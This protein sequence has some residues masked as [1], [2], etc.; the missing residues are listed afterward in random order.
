MSNFTTDVYET[1]RE[2]TNFSKTI[3]SGLDKPE[4]KFIMD[5]MYGVHHSQNVLLSEIS[6][7]LNEPIK[8]SNTIERL[9]DH[10][11]F[12]SDDSLNKIKDNYYKNVI[13]H[14]DKEPLVLLDNS[15]IVKRYG[16]KF[17]D[18]CMVKDAS[19]LDG[20][21][22]PGYHICEAAVV[23]KKEKQPI[24]LYSKLYSTE[25]EEFKSMNDE[26]FKSIEAVK[27]ALQRKCTFVCDR[28]YDANTY[29]DYF[30]KENCNDDFIIRL[31]GNRNLLFKGKSKNVEEMAKRRK[32]KVKMEMYF[33]KEDKTVYVTHTRVELSSHKGKQL[34]LVIVYGLSDTTQMMLLTNKKVSCKEDL[35]KIVR[36]Y[37]SRWRIE[38]NFRFKKEQYKLENMRVRT[39]HAMNVM[40]TIVMILV[41]HIGVLAENIDK[42][43]LVIKMIERGKSL[44][45]KAYLWYYQIAK[46]IKNI[47]MYAHNGIREFQD[48]RK[49]ERYKQLQL[50][51]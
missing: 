46:G 27:E 33:S 18:I 32:G 1:K 7:S 6:R 21:I 41:G 37:M 24:S 25:S 45:G 43:L 36:A 8:L 26:T 40:N 34:T 31:K 35:H 3:C 12:F 50:K 48:I 10:L 2:I 44:K 39:V 19:S 11:A 15:E 29:Y 23:T 49:K 9:S 42:K 4:Q 51:L 17:E 5:M 28:G 13:K 38:E 22:V 14:M 30:L 47:L 16:K 20:D